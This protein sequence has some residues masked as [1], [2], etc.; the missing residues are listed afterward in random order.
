MFLKVQFASLVQNEYGFILLVI[1]T[2]L[3]GNAEWKKKN[4]M[5]A[6]DSNN[7]TVLPRCFYELVLV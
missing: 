4:K 5:Y 3:I 6:V 7:V 2:H 1:A